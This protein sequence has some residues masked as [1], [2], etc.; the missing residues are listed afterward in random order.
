M[1]L[2]SHVP[3]TS[4]ILPWSAPTLILLA[5]HRPLDEANHRRGLR[6]PLDRPLHLPRA[7]HGGDDPL[8]RETSETVIGHPSRGPGT[9]GESETLVHDS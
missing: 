8:H 1:F 7:D 9:A 4:T 6:S 3:S 2:R 5:R